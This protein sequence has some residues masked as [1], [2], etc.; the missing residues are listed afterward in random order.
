MSIRAVPAHPDLIRPPDARLSEPDRI[1]G[2]DV[3]KVY[4]ELPLGQ[5]CCAAC[6][7]HQSH[8]CKH[9]Q[10]AQPAC[11]T[12]PG[13]SSAVRM[14]T[15]ANACCMRCD[16]L[17]CRPHQTSTM[18]ARGVAEFSKAMPAQ[19][20]PNIVESSADPGCSSSSGLSGLH[21]Q[22][23]DETQGSC[24]LSCHSV[25]L[26]TLL[27]SIIGAT[28]ASTFTTRNPRARRVRALPAFKQRRTTAKVLRA[29]WVLTSTKSPPLQP[30]CRSSAHA[31]TELRV[32]A[33]PRKLA[34]T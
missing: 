1:A 20:T 16:N 24:T 2:W 11:Q 6:L 31:S 12:H 7:E 34:G 3:R 29:Q 18:V 13:T 14:R 27:V 8:P 32:A 4:V 10:H 26:A 23:T 21:G 5:T 9:M 25:K 19:R 33:S 17:T 28:H 30:S 15:T 22:G